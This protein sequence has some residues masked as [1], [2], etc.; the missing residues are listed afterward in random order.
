MATPPHNSGS[1]DPLKLMY[2]P[3]YDNAQ[4]HSPMFVQYLEDLARYILDER[5]V[6]N[7]R[8]A[9]IGCGNG[10]FLNKLVRDERAGNTGYGFD[11][12]YKG[13]D[14]FLEGRLRFKR[15]YYGPKYADVPVDVIICRHVIEH[16]SDPLTLLATVR[17]AIECSRHPRAFFET[18][19][20]E[21]ILAQQVIWDFFYEHCSYWSA[22]S[23]TMAFQM[24]GFDVLSVKTIF[25]EQYMLLE[26]TTS[27]LS[28][29]KAVRSAGSIPELARLFAFREAQIL[30]EWRDLIRG[31]R[32]K[33]GVALWGAGAKGVTFAN[34]IDGDRK[35]IRCLVDLNPGKQGRFTPGS[36]HRIVDYRELPQYGVKTV[37]LMNPVYRQENLRLLAVANVNVQLIG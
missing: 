37:I 6:V 28:H 24:A 33:G 32:C 34:L 11:P 4:T 21:W 18:P 35:S 5:Q 8:I 3:R 1:F 27:P 7:A 14:A 20:V 23:L 10:H 31:A 13:P 36:A 15:D 12:S 19:T 2:G 26:A 30:S 22:S 9:E 29:P 17:S 25:G 16:V